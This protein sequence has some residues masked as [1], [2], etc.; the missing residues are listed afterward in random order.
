M[1]A[2]FSGWYTE[3]RWI[4][5]VERFPLIKIIITVITPGIEI[6]SQLTLWRVRLSDK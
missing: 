2:L 3:R 5:A 1:G 4:E 6:V